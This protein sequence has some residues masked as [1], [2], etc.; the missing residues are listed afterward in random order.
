MF[1]CD[2][3]WILKLWYHIDGIMRCIKY[4]ITEDLGVKCMARHRCT[5]GFNAFLEA[6]RLQH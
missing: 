4:N 3:I 5:S 6:W 2:S 1:K